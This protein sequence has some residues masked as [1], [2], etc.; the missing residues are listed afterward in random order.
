MGKKGWDGSFQDSKYRETGNIVNDVLENGGRLLHEPT[1]DGYTHEIVDRGAYISED[2]YFPRREPGGKPHIHYE[3]RSTGEV[4]IDG[5]RI[6]ELAKEGRRGMNT[7]KRE[8]LDREEAR[9]EADDRV[10]KGREL[11]ELGRK[12]ELNKEKLEDEMERVRDSRIPEKDKRALLLKLEE[13][14]QEVERQYE[15][16]V[17]E[18]EKETQAELVELTE[19]MR[20]EA[21]KLKEEE[22][23]LRDVRLD[24]AETD[25]SAVADAAEAGKKA[26]E[27][28]RRE[29]VDKLKLQ[30]EQAADLERRMRARRLSGR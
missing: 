22:E 9:R 25:T 1:P 14:L 11:G 28:M 4:L 18:K 23:H 7:M 10:R 19:I 3:I 15:R 12:F 26:F 30:M 16:D 2:Y 21:D 27:E 5:K 13:A 6:D 8:G 29:Y 17:L 24:V 20:E